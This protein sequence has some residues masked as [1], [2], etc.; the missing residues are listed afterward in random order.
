MERYE[1]CL[2]LLFLDA[3]RYKQLDKRILFS[4]DFED[5]FKINY[6]KASSSSQRSEY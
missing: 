5:T 4:K 2:V 3:F 6:F 1:I